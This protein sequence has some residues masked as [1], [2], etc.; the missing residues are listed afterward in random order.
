VR[1]IMSRVTKERELT[2]GTDWE[3]ELEGR[4]RKET[5]L[6]EGT[7]REILRET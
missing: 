6:V 4:V 2:E 1:E 3:R 7:G 5:Q